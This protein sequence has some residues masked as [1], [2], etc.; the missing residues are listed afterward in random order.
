[1]FSGHWIFAPVWIAG[2]THIVG[3]SAATKNKQ[4]LN[5][6]ATASVLVPTSRTAGVIYAAKPRTEAGRRVHNVHLCAALPVH[7]KS[8]FFGRPNNIYIYVYIRKSRVSPIYSDRCSLAVSRE[9]AQSVHYRCQQKSGVAV[10]IDK[11]Q[12]KWSFADNAKKG[13][14]M[15]AAEGTQQE[16][17]WHQHRLRQRQDKRFPF[18]C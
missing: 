8:G 11:T 1:M 9:C 17:Y 13:F 2:K 3:A 18:F 15:C 16:Q 5:P 6:L 12:V 14:T 10:F 7:C 4:K